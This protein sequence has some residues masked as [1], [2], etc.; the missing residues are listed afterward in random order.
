MLDLQTLNEAIS[1]AVKCD[2]LLFQCCQDQRSWNLPKYSYSHSTTST[3]ILN[4]YSGTEDMR[5]HAGQYKPLTAQEKKCH[6][7]RGL[8]LYC[9][10]GGHK[11]NNYLKKQYCHTFKMMSTT[12]SSNLQPKNGEA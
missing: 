6:F 8:C 3:T 12:T 9:E 10:E 2:N 1:Q 5:I 11:S 7:D 4:P